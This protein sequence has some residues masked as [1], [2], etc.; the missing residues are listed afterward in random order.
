MF[1]FFVDCCFRH[2]DPLGCAGKVSVD[3]SNFEL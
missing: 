3:G 2:V 1:F